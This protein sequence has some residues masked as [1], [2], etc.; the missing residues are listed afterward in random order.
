MQNDTKDKG[1]I[2]YR[3]NNIWTV[4]NAAQYYGKTNDT[5]HLIRKVKQNKQAYGYYW[6]YYIDY[7]SEYNLTC[8]EAKNNLL[9]IA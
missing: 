8:I 9:F 5:S 1:N 4:K 2:D 7:L 3:E 6:K